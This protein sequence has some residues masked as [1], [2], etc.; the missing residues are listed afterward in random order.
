MYVYV[1][2][3]IILYHAYTLALVVV[4]YQCDGMRVVGFYSLAA[5]AVERRRVPS[6]VGRSMPEPVPVILLGQLAVDTDYQGRGLG[7]DLLVDAAKR[8]LSA[9]E[10][11]GARAIVVQALDE[12]GWQAPRGT[13]VT[14]STPCRPDTRPGSDSPLRPTAC[15]AL[16]ESVRRR[17]REGWPRIRPTAGRSR[18]A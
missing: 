1:C 12:A 6:R 8:A 13:R 2:V 5:S 10:F 16:E 18:E 15:V 11:I 7:S 14:G 9:A 3:C 17:R 4:G